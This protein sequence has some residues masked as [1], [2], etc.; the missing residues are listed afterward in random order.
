MGTDFRPETKLA[1]DN[2]GLPASSTLSSRG[3]NSSQKARISSRARCWPK[4]TCA[5]YPKASCLLG[6]ALDIKTERIGEHLVAIAGRVGEHQPVALG[7]LGAAQ[8]C[9]R[10]GR[11]HEM[12]DRRGPANGLLDKARNERG[13][14]LH[15]PELIGI[16]RERPH[17]M[18][19]RA[20]R[21]V[22]ACRGHD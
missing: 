17:G 11:T 22:M 1:S 15:L 3:S 8:F 16:F 4:H 19:R 21:R 10:R 20:R 13:I 7:D 6:D 9:I 18:R 2:R 14:F 5:P 12:L